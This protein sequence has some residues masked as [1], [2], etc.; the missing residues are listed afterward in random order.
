MLA[1]A[2]RSD[3]GILEKYAEL[4]GTAILDLFAMHSAD[5]FATLIA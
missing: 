1:R 5:W 2:K 4:L 3:S